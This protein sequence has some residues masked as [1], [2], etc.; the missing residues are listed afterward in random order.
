MTDYFQY[1]N[2]FGRSLA[3]IV[4]LEIL[5]EK[6][7]DDHEGAVYHISSLS[8]EEQVEKIVSYIKLRN[9]QM[10]NLS[11][12]NLKKIDTDNKVPQAEEE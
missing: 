8:E 2:T 4:F 7:R 5:N 6:V 12:E 11:L 9:E 1:G 10:Q 3:D